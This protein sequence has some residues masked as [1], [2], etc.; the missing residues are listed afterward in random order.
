MI[1]QAVMVGCMSLRLAYSTRSITIFIILFK[2]IIVTFSENTPSLASYT[3]RFTG[4][5]SVC[6]N[7]IPSVTRYS[8]TAIY[9]TFVAHIVLQIA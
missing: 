2:G 8:S 9:M 5:Q 6:S 4:T 1:P 7:T 3:N